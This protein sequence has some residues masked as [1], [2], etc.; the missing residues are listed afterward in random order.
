[1]VHLQNLFI[2]RN[3]DMMADIEVPSFIEDILPFQDAYLSYTS[4]SDNAELKTLSTET[5][6]ET[7]S[8]VVRGS[9]VF[10]LVSPVYRQ[11]MYSQRRPELKPHESPVD[12][13]QPW[14]VNFNS[15]PLLN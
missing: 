3:K 10:R 8:C 14:H 11:N 2:N 6:K 12:L 7:Y 15:F 1:M 5:K 9:E 4:S 13:F